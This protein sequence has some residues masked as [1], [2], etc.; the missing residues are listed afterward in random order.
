MTEERNRQVRLVRDRA[1]DTWRIK[2]V[3]YQVRPVK[4]RVEHEAL[5]KAKLWEECMEVTASVKMTE[6]I[7]E[8][9]DVISVLK[10]IAHFNGISWV[11]VEMMND[12]KEKA[13]GPF[14]E[15]MVWDRTIGES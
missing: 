9:G 7:E 8:L 6:L 15:G 4:G 12:I 5:L 3:E 13:S 1:L 11:E 2:G 10:G 14:F